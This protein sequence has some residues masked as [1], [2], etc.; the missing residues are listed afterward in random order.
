M[1]HY[2]NKNRHL[3]IARP[4]TVALAVFAVGCV[5]DGESVDLR[6]DEENPVTLGDF[7][8][9]EANARASD[10]YAVHETVEPADPHA[11]PPK[12]NDTQL[13]PL[14]QGLVHSIPV[15]LPA[16]MA[17][18]QFAD[19][20]LGGSITT[21]AQAGP[22]CQHYAYD[23]TTGL[24]E[25][26]LSCINPENLESPEGTI[27]CDTFVMPA[28]LDNPGDTLVLDCR[29]SIANSG[30]EISGEAELR[31]YIAA[32]TMRVRVLAQRGGGFAESMHVDST[33][34]IGNAKG[35]CNTYDSLVRVAQGETYFS[36]TFSNL[37]RCENLCV[38]RSGSLE[39]TR[40][41]GSLYDN[42]T[43][44]P[45]ADG[46]WSLGEASGAE[47]PFTPCD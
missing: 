16:R 19:L 1:S 17:V 32:D 14:V 46:E 24:L 4:L 12:L 10:P 3:S 6:V 26:E 27:I 41:E 39:V 28:T 18:N 42:Y 11:S 20:D 44:A 35:A 38:A 43:I 5:T 9:H 7:E 23:E 21:D 36:A 25:V 31:H 22:E 33:H 29:Y 34:F 47:P 45:G 2:T 37:V 13:R 8:R 40:S 15:H 30:G